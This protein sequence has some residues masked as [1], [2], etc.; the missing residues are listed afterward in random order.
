MFVILLMASWGES[1]CSKVG[2]KEQSKGKRTDS[3]KK[4][5]LVRV[6]TYSLGQKSKVKE[7]E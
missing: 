6:P 5:I 3:G 4:V 1:K 7:K 2:S